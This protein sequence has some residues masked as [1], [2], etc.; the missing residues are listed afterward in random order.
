MAYT[1]T[2]LNRPH[3][4]LIHLNPL[5]GTWTEANYDAVKCLVGDL[6]QC[7]PTT[8]ELTGSHLDAPEVRRTLTA[9]LGATNR[10]DCHEMVD[11]PDGPFVIY[12]GQRVPLVGA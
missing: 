3:D 5:A 10:I 12:Q 6:V 9:A 1:V 11:G 7:G 2:S 4:L 8:W